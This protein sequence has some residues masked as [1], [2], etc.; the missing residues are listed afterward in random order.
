MFHRSLIGVPDPPLLLPYHSGT[1]IKRNL[2]RFTKR[3]VVWPN[4]CTE[5]P[6]I[7]QSHV[8]RLTVG[9]DPNDSLEKRAWSKFLNL[10]VFLYHFFVSSILVS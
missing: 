8:D 10:R 6:H 5:L 9:D 3:F 7:L 4:D 1:G 2:H